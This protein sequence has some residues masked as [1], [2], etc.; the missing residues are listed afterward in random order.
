MKQV[1]GFVK[2]Q[3]FSL[4]LLLG[5][6]IGV[7]W[8]VHHLRPPG[9]MSVVEAQGM[10]MTAMR[11]PL[12]AF[13]V[14]MDKVASRLVGG[15]S[16]Y[17]ATVQ[18]L[19]DE[20]VT[21]RV[22][23]LV[24]DLKVYPGDKVQPGQL[25][26]RIDAKE[27]QQK[28]AAGSLAATA[29]N[30]QARAAQSMVSQET[31][32]VARVKA[33]AKTAAAKIEEAKALLRSS[34]SRLEEAKSAVVK[35][36]A[37]IVESQ[38]NLTYAEAN[39]KRNQPLLDGGAISRRE[40]EQSVR[41]RDAAQ[42][43]VDAAKAANRQAKAAVS[44]ATDSVHA[45][46]AAVATA[47]SDAQAANVAVSEANAK[48]ET[49]R[50][51]ATAQGASASATAADAQASQDIASYTELRALSRGVVSERVVSPG[52]PV[53][54]G[55]VI[56][57]LKSDAKLRVQADLPQALAGQVRVGSPAR[58]RVNGK[59]LETKISSVFPFVEGNSRTFRVEALVDNPRNG[60]D[61]GSYAELEVF[62]HD[63]TQGLAVQNEA[64]KTASD[65]THYVWLIKEGAPI[66]D[67]EREYTCTMHPE[68][69]HKGP[70]KC[71]ICD[72]PLVPRDARG[73]LTV[74]RQPVEIGVKDNS[75]TQIVSGLKAGDE[76][77]THG[78][79][80]LF[81]KAAV[82]SAAEAAEPTEKESEKEPAKPEPAMPE[83]KKSM[84]PMEGM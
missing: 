34:Q 69:S 80:E 2:K 72:M 65:G 3:W 11:A 56:L 76:V 28:S 39:V 31:A 83:D 6:G 30:L 8:V 61:V 45:A 21:A 55:Q 25:L 74:E 75:Y 71:P 43:R 46:E 15:S 63:Q 12:G 53:Q 70:G 82:R 54:A 67:K 36:E 58:I 19:N 44:T 27:L 37:D 7:S 26:G 51:Q 10:D 16:V 50:Q 33:E 81:P 59:V 5:V 42:S 20:D 77:T 60:L 49:A 62:T 13:P 48:L 41:D 84:P 52:T 24:V 78:D 23:G 1:L 32:S 22:A 18:A 66:P 40:L 57:R 14:E 47:Q 38:A 9:A 68:V 73:S 29:A 35:S 64:I 79:A 4:L 17:P